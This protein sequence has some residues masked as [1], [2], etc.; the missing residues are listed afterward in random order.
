MKRNA[1]KLISAA[2]FAVVFAV[3]FT[4]CGNDPV[5]PDNPINK[6]GH[7]DPTKMVIELYECHMHADWNKIDVEGGAHQD[8]ET[9]AKYLKKVQEIAFENK[10]GKGWGYADG[11][12]KSF[13]VRQSANYYTGSNFTPAPVYLLF[14]KYYDKKGQLM[15]NQFIEGG[16]DRLHQHYF[17]IS[18]ATELMTGAAL[19]D[20]T[21]TTNYIDYKYTDT[22]P[23]NKT[24]HS[25]EAKITGR[26]N[27]IG[28]KGA[29]RFLKNRVKFD[30]RIQLWHAFKGKKDPAASDFDPFY[31]R[32]A[33]SQAFGT[34]D[35]NVTVPIV[36]YA[37]REEYIDGLESST[38]VSKV[39]ENSYDAAGNAL[40]QA[41]M[42]A[43]NLT[44]TEALTD[45]QKFIWDDSDGESGHVWL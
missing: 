8:P 31:K 23:W 27:P 21:Q 40:I 1:I 41:I 5:T 9:K 17:T 4:A 28:L 6:K 38:D 37:S 24:H 25:G 3:T 20:G 43:F 26:S 29:I 35:I 30:L 16:Q 18:N 42:K 19:A 22:T 14:I 10:E 12:Q 32:S 33:Y 7:E 36:V 2:V 15:N 44:W 45:Y 39:P 13:F 34:S 11:S